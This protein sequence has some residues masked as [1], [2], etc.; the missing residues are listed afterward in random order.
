MRALCE[1]V[2][3]DESVNI[4]LGKK[5]EIVENGIEIEMLDVTNEILREPP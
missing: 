4:E 3:L 5:R 2:W 1:S